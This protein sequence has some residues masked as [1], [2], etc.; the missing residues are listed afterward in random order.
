MT[1]E[2]YPVP[3]ANVIDLLVD[4]VCVVRADTEIVFVSAASERIF[5]YRPEEMI[6]RRMSEFMHPDDRE[7]TLRHAQKLMTDDTPGYFENRYVRKDGSVVDLMWAARWSQEAGVRVAVARDITGRKRAESMQAALY[8]ISEAA[9]AAADL[10]ALFR[11]V[12]EIIAGLLPA[13]NFFVALYDAERDALS[14]PYC[15]D[16]HD[17]APEPLPLD[18][19]TLSA[20]VV[21][22]GRPLLL[23][24]DD[25]ASVSER[26]RAIVAQAPP[27]HAPLAW[28]GVPLVAQHGVIGALVVQSYTGDVTY[29]EDDIHLLQFVSTQVAAAIERKQVEARLN[30]MARYDQLTDLPNRA[31]FHDRLQNA[32]AR[33]RRD[34]ERVGILFLDLDRFKEINDRRGHAVGDRLLCEVARRLSACVRESD[35]VGRLGGDEFAVL[36]PRIVKP[37]GAMAVAE[38]IRRAL[39]Q[40]ID[41]DGQPATISASIGIA[42]Y[43]DHGES[44]DVLLK[45]ADDAMYAAKR[46]GG[47]RLLMSATP[48]SAGP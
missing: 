17:I 30:H 10:D 46:C 24:S 48:P 41:L 31:L 7:R 23:R 14:F 40:P 47:N 29:G 22:S 6:G 16:D 39:H 13:R 18:S 42:L 5:G 37:E 8:D 20:E 2:Q 12:H 33:A 25:V 21:R 4:A 28:L 45:L 44:E 34:L 32:L 9:H 27:G 26:V 35:T 43:P 3:L 38:K 1:P 11:R 19:G 15:V 36:L